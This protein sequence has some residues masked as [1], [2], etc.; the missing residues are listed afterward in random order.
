MRIVEIYAISS[1][2]AVDAR[3]ATCYFL[4]FEDLDRAVMRIVEIYAI[5]SN[6]AVD[7]HSRNLWHGLKST[8]KKVFS[9][10]I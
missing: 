6:S 5:S 10:T 4:L 3:T 1:N 8:L 7:A 2:S 9:W